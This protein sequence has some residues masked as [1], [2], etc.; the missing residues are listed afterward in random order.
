[1]EEVFAQ[2]TLLEFANLLSMSDKEFDEHMK[3][4]KEL[5]KTLRSMLVE[6]AK[7]PA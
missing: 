6:P 3:R 7:I 4:Y 2:G 5:R 1:M